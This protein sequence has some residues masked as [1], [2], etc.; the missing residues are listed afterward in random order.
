MFFSNNSIWL[1]YMLLFCMTSME[2]LFFF[3]KLYCARSERIS[4]SYAADHPHC[5]TKKEG[6]VL[7]VDFL[8]FVYVCWERII[9]V[10][11]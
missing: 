8:V 6:S 7:I 11:T 5:N 1:K 2:G 3:A 4:C 9:C 10:K